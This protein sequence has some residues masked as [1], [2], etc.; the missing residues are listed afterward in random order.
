MKKTLVLTVLM[1]VNLL[2][3]NIDAIQQIN[4]G[5]VD[6][7]Y[8]SHNNAKVLSS[9]G[10]AHFRIPR[11]LPFR[12]I[13]EIVT[14]LYVS[15]FQQEDKSTTIAIGNALTALREIAGKAE[16]IFDSP[17]YEIDYAGDGSVIFDLNGLKD[18]V[19]SG[20]H[21][22]IIIKNP[23]V[24]FIRLVNSENCIIRD[25]EID[26]S[27]LP[28][29]QAVITSV[30]QTKGTF[31]CKV[32]DGFPD[33]EA[34]HVLAAPQNW[35]MLKNPEYPGR[36]KAGVRPHYPTTEIIRLQDKNFRISVGTNYINDFS[37]GDVF[38]KLARYNGAATII[39]R[40]SSK[41]SII[42][43][44]VYASPAGAFK[45]DLSSEVNILDCNVKLYAGRYASSNADCM[46]HMGAGVGPWIEGCLFEGHSDDTFNLKW[47]KALIK[48]QSSYN[49]IT[50][51]TSCDIGELLWVYNPRDGLLIDTIRVDKV[52]REN[53]QTYH[54]TLA[55]NLPVLVTGRTDQRGDMVYFDSRKNESFVFRN[56]IVRDHRRYGILLQS[57]YGLIENNRFENSSNSAITIEN[58]VDWG[59]GLVAE[60]L[61]IRNNMF[62]NNGYDLNYLENK[63]ACV[64]IQMSKLD[65]V[66]ATGSWSGVAPAL[67]RGMKHITI[68]NNDF[69]NWTG[70]AIHVVSA[71]QI[72]IQ[73]NRFSQKKDDS[74]IRIFIEN[75]DVKKEKNVSTSTISTHPERLV[76]QIFCY[77]IAGRLVFMIDNHTSG[78]SIDNLIKLKMQSLKGFYLLKTISNDNLMD[79][80]KVNVL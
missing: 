76:K 78:D 14:T 43:V 24:G 22:R 30:N 64:H 11:N 3:N 39:V 35:S 45:A 40:N 61:L 16:L 46:H 80:V 59:E 36:N 10:T 72:K 67:W 70:K 54:L 27:P 26:Y 31:D 55:G 7:D 28:Y 9:T 1:L 49:E 5:F 71:D 75:A 68:E 52:M 29:V 51:N 74:E 20:N 32:D 42:S 38:I 50:L 53:N 13:G 60:H 23:T 73:N 8:N 69:V 79:T 63:R 77:D 62:I 56:N 65:N 47:R 12:E 19:I 58:A 44:T 34:Q 18:K 4:T 2:Q 17:F 25:F 6:A 48:A 41:I 21:T 57:G 37:V 66:N 33:F 15:D